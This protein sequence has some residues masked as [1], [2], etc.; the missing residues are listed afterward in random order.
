MRRLVLLVLAALTLVAAGCGGDEGGGAQEADQLLQRGFST[1]VDSGEISMEMELQLEGLEGAD[2]TFR[3]ELSGPFRSRGPTKLPDADLDFSASGQGV[4][5]EGGVVILPENAWIEFGGETYEV[6]EELWSRAQGTLNSDG[7][8][9]TFSDAKVKPLDWVEGAETSE[10]EQISGTE[11]TKVTGRLD[12]AAMLG[13]FSR[14]SPDSAAIPRETLGQ[15]DEAIGPVTFEA[16]IGDD[17]IWRRVSSRTNFTVPEGRRPS[18][19]GLS[20]GRVSLE[21]TLDAPNEEV[22]IESPGEGRPIT[23][24]LRALGIAPEAL[25]GPGFEVPEPG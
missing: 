23:E 24:L 22:A 16:W 25:L 12:V 14:L 8:P 9:E 11:T 19:G 5:L 13:D 2:G 10:G 15:V 4:N 21:M 1:D 18:T 20:G 6:G 3:L 17:D 7:G